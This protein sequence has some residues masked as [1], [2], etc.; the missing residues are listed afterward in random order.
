M[1]TLSVVIPAL[2]E[3]DGIADI[4]E[5]VLAIKEPLAEVGVSALELIVVDD[6][7][8]DRTPTIVAGYPEVVLIQHP[9]NRGYGAAIKTGFRQAKGDLLAFLDADGTYPPEAYPELCRPILE[10]G[11]DLVIGSRMSGAES[12]MPL[13]R[14][15]GNLIFA[16]LVT[17]IGNQRVSD[18]ASGQRVLR[19]DALSLLYPLPDGL[20]FTPVMSTRAIH[21]NLHIVEVPIAYA[22]RRGRSKLSV[23]KDGFR[24]LS[25]IVVTAMTYNPVRILGAIGAGLVVLAILIALFAGLIGIGEDTAAWPFSRFFAA[26]VIAAVGINLFSTGAMFNY[27]VSLFHKR[28]VRQGL[29]GRPLFRTPLESHFGW[30]GL[31]AVVAGVVVYGLAVLLGLNSSHVV[32]SWFAPAVSSV[33]VLSGFQLMTAWMLIKVLAQLSQREARAQ[34]DLGVSSERRVITPTSR[35]LE[36]VKIPVQV[37]RPSL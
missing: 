15:L 1:S 31:L 28:Q 33:L 22:E 37:Q 9:T 29:F 27:L 25:S 12:D 34:D 18:S 2:N 4:I 13:V 8:R 16:T 7:S 35:G 6:G 10:D 36:R 17:L 5:R 24:F 11:A 32:P 26:F 21:E 23:V 19:R 3:E 20:N 14:R 30:M